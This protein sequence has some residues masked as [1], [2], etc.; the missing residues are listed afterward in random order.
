MRTK[1]WKGQVLQ[2]PLVQRLVAKEHER[3]LRRGANGEPIVGQ[4]KPNP[5]TTMVV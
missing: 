2:L 4:T 1:I 3:R 5:M